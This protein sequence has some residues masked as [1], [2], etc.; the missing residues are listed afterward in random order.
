MKIDLDSLKCLYQA[1]TQLKPRPDGDCP[2]PKL[3]VSLLRSEL[4]RKKAEKII[5]HMLACPNCREEFRFLLGV[6]RAEKTLIDEL[7]VWLK[8]KSFSVGPEKKPSRFRVKR[9]PPFLRRGPWPAVTV[10]TAGFLVV[11][12]VLLVLVF[13]HPEKYRADSSVRVELLEPVDEKVSLSSPVFLWKSVRGAHSYILQLFDQNL[14]LLWKSDRIFSTSFILPAEVA[15]RLSPGQVHFWMVVA[16]SD[17]EE[18]ASSLERFVP[19]E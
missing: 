7:E 17:S 10:A 15:H 13:R 4:S 9:W 2:D 16:F 1:Q 5:D 11:I 6:F 3:L 8:E 14:K 18:V 19:I 12:S